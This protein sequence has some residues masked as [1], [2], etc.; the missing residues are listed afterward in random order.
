LRSAFAGRWTDCI[1]TKLAAEQ[2]LLCSRLCTRQFPSVQCLLAIGRDHGW[3]WNTASVWRMTVRSV[4]ATDKEPDDV[5]QIPSHD[6]DA[7]AA[8]DVSRRARR[9][10]NFGQSVL[11]E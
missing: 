5:M 3:H 1:R 10:D 2:Y 4:E 8:G 11:A 9:N 6:F 7:V